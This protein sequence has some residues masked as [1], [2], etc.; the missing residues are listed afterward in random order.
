MYPAT[1][2]T[3]SCLHWSQKGVWLCELLEPL[4][5]SAT[6]WLSRDA[7][8]SCNLRKEMQ[9]LCQYSGQKSRSVAVL[10]KGACLPHCPTLFGICL[11]GYLDACFPRRESDDNPFNLA[12]LRAKTKTAVFS[13]AS[14]VSD[15]S[16]TDGA[17]SPLLCVFTGVS[18]LRDGNSQKKI[19]SHGEEKY[20]PY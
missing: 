7:S 12:R 16:E 6:L 14:A 3:Q 17:S 19:S 2:T 15:H 20:H 5:Q 10:N 18:G 1:N 9:A 8:F 4:L 13:F 11:S